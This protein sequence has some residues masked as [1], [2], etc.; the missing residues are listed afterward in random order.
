MVT[1]GSLSQLLAFLFTLGAMALI[2]L[3]IVKNDMRFII[4]SRRALYNVTI[5]LV[6]ASTA[7]VMLFASDSFQVEYVASYSD[8]ALPIFYKLTAFWAGQKGSLLFWALTLGLITAAVVRNT[9]DDLERRATPY[10]Y[11]VLAGVQS[12][13][14]FLLVSVTSPFELLNFIPADGQGLNPMLQNPG[15]IFHP[16]TLFLGYVGFTVPFAY[17][18]AAMVTGEL[19]ELWL[20]KTRIWNVLSWVLLAIGIILGGQWAYVELGWG[21]YWAWDP[22]ENASFIPWLVATAFIHTAII[23]ERRNIMR[24]WNMVLIVLTFVLTIFGTYLVRSGVLQ[25][26][27]DFGA[28]GLGGYFLLFMATVLFGGIYLIA[29][30]YSELRTYHSLE[31]YLSRESTFLFNN[32]VLLALAFSTLLGTLFPLISEVFTG[33]KITV[34]QP[35][36]NRVNT[37]LFLFLILLTGLCPLMGWRKASRD[38][39]K[40]NFMIPLGVTV[41]GAIVLFAAGIRG[42]Y[43]LLAFTLSVFVVATIFREFWTGTRARSRLTGDPAFKAFP[44][45]LWNMRRRYGGFIAHLGVVIMVIGITGSSAFKQ[46]S[47]ATLNRGQVLEVGSYALRYDDMKRYKLYNRDIYSATLSV[48]KKGRPLGTMNAEKRYYVNADQPTTEVSLRMNLLED[49]YVTM[50]AM[51]KRQEIT[52]RAAINPLLVWVW[53]GGTVMVLGGVMAVIP[54]RR[55][56]EDEYDYE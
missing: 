27:H 37:P 35:F 51:G 56:R 24:V 33:N 43:P 9:R 25:S 15:M 13:F 34:S 38:N 40:K 18:V 19:D 31:S 26:V 12:F 53:I 1:L 50:P 44:M 16:P 4:S 28:T 20:K 36:F 41:T 8:R 46:E 3:G 29:E 55:K 52:L 49:L 32:V 23:Q 6:M 22:V 54:R 42:V 17:A 39:L 10:I 21:G 7:L 2:L 5:F 47:Q 45:L 30:S 48:F 11:L 14:L